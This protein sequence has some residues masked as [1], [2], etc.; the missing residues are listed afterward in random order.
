VTKN[1][2]SVIRGIGWKAFIMVLF[3]YVH[4]SAYDFIPVCPYLCW[5]GHEADCSLPPSAEVKYARNYTSTPP[6]SC[7]SP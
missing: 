7:C 1:T 5:L 4:I 3:L 6:M 2:T